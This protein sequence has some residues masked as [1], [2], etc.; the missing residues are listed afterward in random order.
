ML[1]F[2]DMPTIC[3]V[4]ESFDS[5]DSTTPMSDWSLDNHSSNDSDSDND[6]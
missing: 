4:T 6:D 1:F 2:D 5:S 3:D